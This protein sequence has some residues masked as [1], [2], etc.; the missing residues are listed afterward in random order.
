[1]RKNRNRNE[2]KKSEPKPEE[3]K[4]TLAMRIKAHKERHPNDK[5]VQEKRIPGGVQYI[6]RRKMTDEQKRREQEL[7][8]FY[9]THEWTGFF[10]EGWIPQMLVVDGEEE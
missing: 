4:M 2:Q 5:G 6:T 8:D 9:E 3:P 1:M 10:N 7:E